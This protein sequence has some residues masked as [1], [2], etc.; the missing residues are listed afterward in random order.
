MLAWQTHN[1][2]YFKE[3]FEMG[4]FLDKKDEIIKASSSSNRKTFNTQEFNELAT[5]LLNEPDYVATIA[6]TKNGEYAE[7]DTTPVKDLRK[8]LIGGV[9]KAAGHDSAEQEKFV[10]EYQFSTLPLYPFVSEITEQYLRCGKALTLRPKSDLRATITLEDK[11]EEIKE[12]KVPATGDVRK[13][14]MG[15][16]KKVKVKST[17][18]ANLREKL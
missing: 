16:Y 17:C 14:K 6:V 4:R 5:A 7:E 3:E 18:P 2:N 11:K 9:L 8:G 12:S 15:A 1:M 13:T 10:N